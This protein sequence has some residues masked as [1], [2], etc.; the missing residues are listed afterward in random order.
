MIKK[1]LHYKYI[2]D[3]NL[4]SK[5]KKFIINETSNSPKSKNASFLKLPGATKELQISSIKDATKSDFS[6][7]L[8]EV[9]GF[10]KKIHLLFLKVQ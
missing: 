1:S 6:S 9:Y 4:Q 10:D 5:T 7:V 8:S 2:K 3:N